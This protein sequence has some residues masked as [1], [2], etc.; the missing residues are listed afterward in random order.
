MISTLLFFAL[1][2]YEPFQGAGHVA[3]FVKAMASAQGLDV[4]YSVS[5][6][7]GT[8][9]KYHFVVARPDKVVIESGKQTLI[10]DGKHVTTYYKETNLYWVEEQS[11]DFIGVVLSGDDFLLWRPFLSPNA[12]DSLAQTRR[13]GTKLRNGETLNVISG[14]RDS[15]G[16]RTIKLY[17]GLQDHLVRQAVLTD[18]SSI[19]PVSKIF[20]VDSISTK[21]IEESAFVFSPPNGSRR[22]TE[23]EMR[24]E[25]CKSLVIWTKTGGNLG[26]PGGGVRYK[27]VRAGSDAI[28]EEFGQFFVDEF[29]KYPLAFLQACNIRQV[30]LVEQLM[31]GNQKRNGAAA[32]QINA[33]AFDIGLIANKRHI[34]N[35]IHHEFFHYIEQHFNGVQSFKDPHWA[36]LNP[37][38]FRYLSS[39]ADAFAKG[40]TFEITHPKPGIINDYCLYAL[41]EDKAEVWTLNFFPEQWAKVRPFLLSDPI[42]AAKVRFLRAFARSKCKAMDDAYWHALTGDDFK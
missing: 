42:V 7:G 38:G 36:A 23:M 14:L 40:V 4:T 17:L 32:A 15:S 2:H 35:S 31:V 3:P 5:V 39:G 33:L 8:E 12:F 6:V 20:S 10:A 13:E 41:E 9:E 24:I 29:S 18:L 30:L 26:Y 25:F 19:E 28:V 37:K 22:I 21:Q 34:Q 16:D 1:S 27:P 11:S